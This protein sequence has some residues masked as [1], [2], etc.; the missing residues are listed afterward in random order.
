[1][2]ITIDVN[3]DEVVRNG[4]DKYKQYSCID[5]KIQKHREQK[6]K[7]ANAYFH[8]LAR[9][10]AAVL[11]VPFAQAKNMLIYRYGQP[12][13][14]E[15]GSQLTYVSPAPVDF[16]MNY[17]AIHTAPIG[18]DGENT[19][20]AV[21]RGVRSYSK[22]EMSQLIDGTVMEAIQLGVDVYPTSKINEIKENWKPDNK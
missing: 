1:M 3:E 2:S 14:L 17:E 6:S 19:I 10:I 4:Y 22:A 21:Y 13:L 7:E 11:T 20:Y 8:A 18:T 5:I 16:M 9:Q 12:E 15:D